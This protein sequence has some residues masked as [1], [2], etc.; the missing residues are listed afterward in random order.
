[1][2][3]RALHGESC[4]T[5]SDVHVENGNGET[6]FTMETENSDGSITEFLDTLK[7]EKEA[8]ASDGRESLIG[9]TFGTGR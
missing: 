6:V 9:E 1:M 3:A 8:E 4:R 7:A 5:R 2:L